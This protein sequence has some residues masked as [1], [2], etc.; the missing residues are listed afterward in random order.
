MR[1]GN[2]AGPSRSAAGRQVRPVDLR[3]HNR[4]D[5]RE[6]GLRVRSLRH[7]RVVSERRA[8][9]E[10][11]DQD[12]QGQDAADADPISPRIRTTI[13]CGS[14]RRCARISRAVTVPTVDVAGWWDQEDFYGP[15]ASYA[16]HGPD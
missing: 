9:V 14:V 4:G 15:V 7:V 6:L 11:P 1:S 2:G 12:P 5:A 8:V 10:H 16:E 3:S 13:S